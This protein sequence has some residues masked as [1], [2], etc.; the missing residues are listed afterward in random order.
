MLDMQKAA[1]NQLHLDMSLA[2]IL[3]DVMEPVATMLYQRGNHFQVFVDCPKNLVVPTDRL[4]LK[5]V[6]LNLAS[7]SR[8]FVQQ[9]YI[10]LRAVRVDGDVQLRVEDSDPGIPLYTREQL[11]AKFQESLDSAF[12]FARIL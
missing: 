4:R 6:V 3:G 9:G 2:E 7:N 5:Q 8:K 1:G 11:F 10:R 12:V